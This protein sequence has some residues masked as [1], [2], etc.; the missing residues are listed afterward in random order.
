MKLRLTEGPPTAAARAGFSV[1]T[2]YR[3][4]QDPRLPSQGG[5][6]TPH[7]NGTQFNG[8]FATIRE[9]FVHLVET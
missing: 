9:A 8:G 2:A 4:E 1:A 6:L 7:W 5:L 3:I